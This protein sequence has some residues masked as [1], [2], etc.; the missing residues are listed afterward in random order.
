[1]VGE[2]QLARVIDLLSVS[3]VPTTSILRSNPTR[4]RPVPQGILARADDEELSAP[5]QG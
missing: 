5:G 3:G 4:R 1:M 2:H